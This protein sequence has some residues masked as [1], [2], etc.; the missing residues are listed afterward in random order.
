MRV[1]IREEL[2]YSKFHT[3]LFFKLKPLIDFTLENSLF[4]AQATDQF[5]K[6]CNFYYN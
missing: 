5:S 4:I 2:L 3:K 6:I 1:V